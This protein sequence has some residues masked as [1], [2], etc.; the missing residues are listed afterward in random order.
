MDLE[1]IIS[2]T[3][4]ISNLFQTFRASKADLTIR[5]EL[6]E[7]TGQVHRMSDVSASLFYKGAIPKD[8][9]KVDISVTLRDTI[10]FATCKVVNVND[11]EITLA[12]PME[13]EKGIKRKFQRVDTEGDLFAK[14]NVISNIDESFDIDEQKKKIPQQFLHLYKELT[15]P[16]PDIK[17]ILPLL[18][19]ELKKKAPLFEIKL[20]QGNEKIAR[21]VDILKTYKQTIFVS[22]T[23][24]T[25]SYL[26]DQH[27]VNAISFL[28]YI[29]TLKDNGFDDDKIKS[30]LLTVMKEDLATRALSYICSP[31]TLFGHVIGHIF[32]GISEGAHQIFRDQDIYFVQ[33]ACDIISEAFA[34]G[35]L[36]QLDTGDEFNVPVLDLSGGGTLL[37]LQDPF[38][39][40]H[41]V[42]DMRLR[43]VIKI[44]DSE[45][46]AVAK[47]IRVNTENME[48]GEATLATKFTEIRWSEQEI[49]DKYV[50]RKVEMEKMKQNH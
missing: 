19:Q 5:H 41:L 28:P 48:P 29:Q 17:K 43:V 2:D 47:I 36:H 21:R 1:H 14:F 23:K 24:D 11:G 35:K 22:N 26:K 40:K 6:S 18:A 25:K 45:V 15:K 30:V 46:K 31:I 42:E 4:S 8:I 37:K 16:V 10:Y 49:I 13:V 3:K 38:I 39:L 9:D 34:K 32:L 27:N 20:Y 50:N 7:F 12:F 33:S 44:N